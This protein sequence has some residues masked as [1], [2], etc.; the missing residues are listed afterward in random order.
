M[1]RVYAMTD[2]SIR[3][4]CGFAGLGVLTTMAAL[5]YD[6][7]LSFRS[8]GVLT[9]ATGFTLWLKA[10]GVARQ[11]MLRTEV[12]MLLRYHDAGIS[13]ANARAVLPP[14]LRERYMWHATV[15]GC[16]AAVFW[17]IAGLMAL[18]RG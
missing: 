18:L 5:S 8:G 2:L 9:F 15:A 6:P 10:H 7:V 12:W 16:V 13:P 11:N 1:Q 14:V 4:A 3:R 17:V